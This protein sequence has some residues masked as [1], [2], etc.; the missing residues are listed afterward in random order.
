MM[1]LLLGLWLEESVRRD[2]YVGRG[3]EVFLI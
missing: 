2:V 3:F 1:W